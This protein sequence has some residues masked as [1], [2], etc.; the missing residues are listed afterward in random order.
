MEDKRKCEH[1]GK[2]YIPKR[3]NAKYCSRECSKKAD[4]INSMEWY[5]EWREKKK[6]QEEMKKAG[7]NQ[8]LARI[9]AAAREAGM[10][11]GEYVSKNGK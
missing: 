1:C 3:V 6:Q 8:E 7:K 4:R 11:Y 10:T 2:E 9:N 5:R